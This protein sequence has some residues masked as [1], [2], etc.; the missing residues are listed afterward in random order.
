VIKAAAIPGVRFEVAPAVEPSTLRSDV[1]GFFGRAKRG[2]VGQPM[3]VVGWRE[4]LRLFGGLTRDAI[5]PYA[6]RGYFENEGQVGHVMR[7]A[8]PSVDTAEF[9][10]TIPP[11]LP[12]GSRFSAQQYR[13]R[14]TSP[15]AWAEGTEVTV[16][17]RRDGLAGHSEVDVS[18]RAAGEPVELFT[19]LDPA[20]LPE[21]LGS[22]LI[23][24]ETVGSAPPSGPPPGPRRLSFTFVLSGGLDDSPGLAEYQ[25]A[26]EALSE[27]SEVAMVSAPDLHF[28]LPTDDDRHAVLGAALRA[29]TDLHDRLVIVD[30]PPGNEDARVGLAWFEGLRAVVDADAL[31]SGAAYHPQLW[32][33]DPLGGPA[34][35]QRL[36]PPS[37]LVAGVMSRLD[38]ERGSHYTPANAPI[39]EAVDVS[40]AYDDDDG[41][42]LATNGVNLLICNCGRGLQVWG[43]RTLD[44]VDPTGRFIAHRRMTHRLVRAIRRVAEPLVFDANSPTLWLALTRAITAV[45]LESFRAGALKGVRA[46]EAFRVQ[47]D[48]QTNPPDEQDLGRCVCLISVA[49]A[50]PMEFITLRVALSADGSIEVT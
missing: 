4:Y 35:P 49:P 28:D 13:W 33:P 22:A 3:R 42:L 24:V 36:L 7:L 41:G 30:A 29:A 18:V 31:R 8:G 26:V 21:Q 45:L 14:A 25:A 44:R 9:L 43:G 1:A 34:A 48:D 10:L 38:R 12:A 27:V 40:R 11:G 50:V 6:V 15:G 23:E 32:V 17:Y 19:N 5:M 46:E 20:A 47:C 16:D 2:P 37:G 39:F